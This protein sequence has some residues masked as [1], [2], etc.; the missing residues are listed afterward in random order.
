MDDRCSDRPFSAFDRVNIYGSGSYRVWESGPHSIQIGMLF[1]SRGEV[2]RLAFPFPTFAYRYAGKDLFASIGLPMFLLWKPH[3]RVMLVCTGMLPG[4]GSA[5]V[6]F[7]LHEYVSLSFSLSRQK[8]PFY[9]ATYPYRDWR[10]IEYQLRQTLNYH[11]EDEERKKLVLETNQLAVGL[12][13]NYH[14]DIAVTAKA[15]L[16]FK[17]SYYLTRNI[18]DLHPDRERIADSWFV[19]GMVQGV[20]LPAE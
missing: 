13:F 17:S 4:V 6:S 16:Q 1:S 19:Q 11:D 15:G 12:G 8:E 5:L 2:W 9:P 14:K 18:N 7:S 10:R 20:I 3:R